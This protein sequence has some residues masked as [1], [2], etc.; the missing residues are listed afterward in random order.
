MFEDTKRA[1][2]RAEKNWRKESLTLDDISTIRPM[3]DPESTYSVRA[4]R[5]FNSAYWKIYGPGNLMLPREWCKSTLHAG[6]TLEQTLD[7]L[8]EIEKDYAPK[9]LGKDARP[10]NHFTKIR[11]LMEAEE[12]AAQPA[13]AATATQQPVTVRAP[14]VLKKTP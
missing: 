13:P 14:L 4:R 11:A 10:Y 7:K 2:R 12:A 3:D 6:L 9:L 1:F 5:Q 8:A